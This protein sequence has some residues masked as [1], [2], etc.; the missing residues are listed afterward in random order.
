MLKDKAANTALNGY[1]KKYYGS[2]C[3]C[4]MFVDDL[5]SSQ[6]ALNNA[7]WGPKIRLSG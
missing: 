1:D 3:W 2:H 5:H 7:Y 6:S 4:L